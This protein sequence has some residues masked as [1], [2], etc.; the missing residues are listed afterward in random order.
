MKVK[1]L[2]RFKDKYTKQIYDKGQIIEVSNERYAEINSTAYGILVQAITVDLENMTKAELL[3]YAEA[4]G[5]EGL[6][7][8]MTKAEIIAAL[9]G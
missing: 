9:E 7:N 1:V 4:K 8:R 2:R 5:I 3:E 6:N